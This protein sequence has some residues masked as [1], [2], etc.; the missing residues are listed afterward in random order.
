MA[1]PILYSLLLLPPLGIMV[2]LTLLGT[3]S[4]CHTMIT[5]Y[6]HR[7][8]GN[9]LHPNPLLLVMELFLCGPFLLLLCRHHRLGLIR[10]RF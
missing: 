5:R 9:K 3:L 4:T 1:N 6:H 8:S 2:T 10:P 7:N